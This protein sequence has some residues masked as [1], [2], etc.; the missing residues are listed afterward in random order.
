M[1]KLQ[2]TNVIRGKGFAGFEG[3][4]LYGSRYARFKLL[5]RY[6]FE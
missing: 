3:E 6:L 1:K 5:N 4:T 2:V